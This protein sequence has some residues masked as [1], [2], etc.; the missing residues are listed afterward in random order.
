ME[1]LGNVNPFLFISGL[2]CHRSIETS[3][4]Q[5]CI[6]LTIPGFHYI[7][8]FVSCGDIGFKKHRTS[9]GLLQIVM[10]VGCTFFL[11]EAPISHSCLQADATLDPAS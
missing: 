2:S 1:Q 8:L 6:K 11:F 7:F 4:T 10:A 5:N 3:L 9:I